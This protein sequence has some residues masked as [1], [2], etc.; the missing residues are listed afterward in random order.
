MRTIGLRF[1]VTASAQGVVNSSVRQPLSRGCPATLRKRRC[2][3]A[4]QSLEEALRQGI[5]TGND[6]PVFV[7]EKSDVDDISPN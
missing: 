4:I 7:L 1:P 5:I 3:G 2:S 6:G